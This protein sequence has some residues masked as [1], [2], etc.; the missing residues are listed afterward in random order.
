MSNTFKPGRRRDGRD[1]WGRRGVP[2]MCKPHCPYWK[3][4]ATRIERRKAKDACDNETAAFFADMAANL[5][6]LASKPEKGAF[7]L[8]SNV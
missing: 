1:L 4:W 7:G 6:R 2:G 8:T 3:K 5:D